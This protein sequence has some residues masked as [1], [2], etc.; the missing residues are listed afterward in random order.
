MLVVKEDDLKYEVLSLVKTNRTESQRPWIRSRTTKR[1]EVYVKLPYTF[2]TSLSTKTHI[3][4]RRLF[5]H[6]LWS[7]TPLRIASSSNGLHP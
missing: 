2:R 5:R 1:L 3:A 7:L 6:P 4:K